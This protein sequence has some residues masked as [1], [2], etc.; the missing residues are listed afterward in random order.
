MI[1]T[2]GSTVG[3]G[4]FYGRTDGGLRTDFE[5]TVRRWGG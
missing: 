1:F 3:D 5:V 2:V 4:V